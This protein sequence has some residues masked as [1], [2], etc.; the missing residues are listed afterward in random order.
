MDCDW[1]LKEALPSIHIEY[2]E[3]LNAKI[4]QYSKLPLTWSSCIFLAK[5]SG[6]YQ[7]CKVLD[8]GMCT[9]LTVQPFKEAKYICRPLRPLIIFRII[10]RCL[11]HECDDSTQKKCLGRLLK[12]M[13]SVSH[14]ALQLMNSQL[15]NFFLLSAFQMSLMPTS[16]CP[17]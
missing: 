9:L 16:L 8:V 14:L 15:T 1:H 6:K 13:L 11:P 7:F 12:R 3:I 10:L 17:S 4:L 5:F 2:K